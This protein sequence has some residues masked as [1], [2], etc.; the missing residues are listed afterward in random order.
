[1]DGTLEDAGGSTTTAEDEGRP[2]GSEEIR[3]W[4]DNPDAGLAGTG[5]VATAAPPASSVTGSSAKLR[6][7]INV[8]PSGR[9]LSDDVRASLEAVRRA[10]LVAR[11]RARR[12]TLRARLVAG[13]VAAL[14]VVGLFVVRPRLRAG[15]VASAAT[16]I[17]QPSPRAEGSAA[18][19][20]GSGPSPAGGLLA[21]G[22]AALPPKAPPAFPPVVADATECQDHYANKR[23]HAAADS[24]VAAFAARPDDAELALHATEALYAR[25]RLSEAREWAQKTL[26]LAPNQAIA[27]GILGRIERRSG[28]VEAAARTFRRYLAV[29]PRGWQAPEAHAALRAARAHGGRAPGPVSTVFSPRAPITSPPPPPVRAEDAPL[30][31]TLEAQAAPAGQ[32]PLGGSD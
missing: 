9:R 29:A 19:A 22:V 27:L 20:N 6:L 21:A 17:P 4:P 18:M 16:A 14:A 25:D 31:P 15:R 12:E 24:C 5:S 28:D 32:A 7:T 11:K 2:G 30:P 3:E 26:A 23:W 13:G 10:Q 1:M 8:S